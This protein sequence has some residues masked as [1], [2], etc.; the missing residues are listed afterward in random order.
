MLCLCSA[1]KLHL[2]W[3][4]SRFNSSTC[5]CSCLINSLLCRMFSIYSTASLRIAPLFVFSH[6]GSSFASCAI[7]SLIVSRRFRSTRLWFSRRS[8][9]HSSEPTT[10][11]VRC[12]SSPLTMLR[13][14]LLLQ[15]KR[16]TVK[17]GGRRRSAYLLNIGL[18]SWRFMRP[19]L[20]YLDVMDDFSTEIVFV[21]GFCAVSILQVKEKMRR[22]EE[23]RRKVER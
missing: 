22:K 21:C 4:F 3:L 2:S 12:V 17:K 19:G 18:F 10:G 8:W 13:F 14:T 23:E 6:F 15:K 7:C 16:K 9:C 11:R 5:C 20:I 1:A